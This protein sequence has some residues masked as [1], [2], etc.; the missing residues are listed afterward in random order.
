M[1]NITSNS[2]AAA[3]GSSVKNVVFKPTAQVVPRKILIIGTGD[4]TTEAANDLNTP[5][6]VTSPEDVGA[7]TGFGFMLYRLAKSAYKG[8]K[9]ILTYIIQ[10]AEPGAGVQATGDI[11]FT[12]STGVLAGTIALYIAGER[13]AVTVAAGT[14]ADDI[15]TAVVAA[16]NA[17]STLPVT[18][19]VDG[20]TT[21]QVNFTAK[22]EGTYGNGIDISLNLNAGEELPSGVTTAITDMSSGAGIPD[23]QDALDALGTGDGANEDYFTDVIYAG[24]GQDSATLNA[25]STYV[26]EGNDFTGLYDKVVHK[27]FRALVGDVAAGSGGLSALVSLGGGRKNDRANG[28]IAVPGSQSHPAEIAAQAMGVMAKINNNLAE[29]NYLDIVLEGVWP[30]AKSDRWTSEYNNRDTAVKAGVSPT[31]VKSG[32]VVMQN[33]VTFYHPDSVP[34]T[35]NGYR[36]MRNISILQNWLNAQASAFETEKW[37]GISIVADTQNVTNVESRKKARDVEAVKDELL[38]LINSAEANAWIYSASFSIDSLKEP[39]AVT[40]R[41]GGDGFVSTL[42]IVLSGEGNILDNITEFDTSIAVFT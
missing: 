27:P 3:V 34:V 1:S 31:F 11:D 21:A 20:A 32:S 7:K 29:Q 2:L 9:G 15:A 26:G 42:K 23:I 10:Q 25:V 8:S 28:V 41:T 5:I 33:V 37:D 6:L 36:S 12:G 18:A 4:P 30:G 13:V 38:A 17:D 39:T 40:V 19:A 35:S 24:Y 16:V 14:S 22:S